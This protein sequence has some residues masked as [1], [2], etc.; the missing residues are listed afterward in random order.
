MRHT[1]VPLI[2]PPAE[3]S[4]RARA[5]TPLPDD[6]PGKC[7]TLEHFHEQAVAQPAAHPLEAPTDRPTFPSS[8]WSLP[9]NP[10]HD[11]APSSLLLPPCDEC[12]PHDDFHEARVR[13]QQRP[14]LSSGGVHQR[15][16]EGMDAIERADGVE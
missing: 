8:E 6:R 3:G 15:H 5:C 16:E 11:I 4:G 9:S 1:A 12:G 7:T 2:A 13:E 10:S 14:H